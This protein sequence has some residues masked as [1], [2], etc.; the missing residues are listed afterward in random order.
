MRIT[1]KSDYGLRAMFELARS[2]ERTPISIADI[3]A[4]H[5]I[6]DPFLEK[7][8]QEL[9]ESGLVEAIHGRGGGYTLKKSPAQ[10]SIRDIVRALEG[11]VALVTCL[12]PELRC[13]IEGGCPTSLIWNL[14][15]AKFEESLNSLT[16]EDILHSCR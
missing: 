14:I 2:Y 9:R 6:P 8:M 4:R 12:D 5:G 16:L 1:R 3:A 11:P 7:I 13:Q 10:I 15:N